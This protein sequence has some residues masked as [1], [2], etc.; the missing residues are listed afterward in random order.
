MTVASNEEVASALFHGWS[1]DGGRTW[2]TDRI[3]DGDN[4]GFACCDPS[5]ASD[6]FGNIFLTY[7]SSSIQVKIAISTDGGVSF[8]PLP[9][10]SPPMLPRPTGPADR[11]RPAL[12]HRRKGSG[13]DDLYGGRRRDPGVRRGG[14][15]TR[16]G[17][18]LR[19]PGGSQR[20]P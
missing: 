19:A 16:A 8:S 9:F 11:R 2:S 7:L 4:L 12:H 13:L 1:T 5:L 14:E 10:S 17:R 6:E 15:R 3:A 20:W 18:S